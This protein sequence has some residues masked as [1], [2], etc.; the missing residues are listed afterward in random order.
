MV[1]T[2]PPKTIV[3]L[4][5]LGPV[6]NTDTKLLIY[7]LFQKGRVLAQ[8][9]VSSSVSE[10]VLVGHL[11]NGETAPFEEAAPNLGLL[12][13]QHA[14]AEGVVVPVPALE[15]A[16]DEESQHAGRV[17]FRGFSGFHSGVALLSVKR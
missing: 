8:D 1:T 13:R 6:A 10:D 17:L 11:K 16:V 5:A 12:D 4:T 3:K 2:R 15:R 14:P 7:G 9:G